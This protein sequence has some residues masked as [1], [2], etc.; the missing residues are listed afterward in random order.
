MLYLRCARYSCAASELWGGAVD[1]ERD[2]VLFESSS[3]LYLISEHESFSENRHPLSV[4]A[5]SARAG[6][7]DDVGPF[8]VSEPR[9]AEHVRV[10]SAARR[11]REQRVCTALSAGAAFIAALSLF[12]DGFRVLAGT[13]AANQA[14]QLV[15]RDSF[16][17]MVGKSARGL[18]VACS[19][20][21]SPSPCRRDLRQ[22]RR[23]V[24]N[25]RDICRPRSV[26]AIGLLL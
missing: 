21:R 11:R 3:R 20:H 13:N 19:T 17:A 8:F 22:R 4:N 10:W 1:V 12:D 16:S 26:T 5:I 7:L 24:A 9:R 6:G 18:S 14:V 2:D 23:D 25:T 15:A